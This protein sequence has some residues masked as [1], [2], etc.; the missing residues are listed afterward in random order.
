MTNGTT[1]YGIGSYGTIQS[2]VTGSANN[3]LSNLNTAAASFTLTNYRHFY[4]NQGTIGAG[5][6]ITNQYGVYVESNLT[7]ATNNYGL[8]SIIPSGTNRW[9]LY[10]AGTA[11]NYMAGKLLIGSTTDNGNTL[12]V[13]GALTTSSD[14]FINGVNIG[15]GANSLTHNIRIGAATLLSVTTGD[16]NVAIGPNALQL[17]TTGF[18][19]IAIGRVSLL[20]NTTGNSN[21]AV[22]RSTL[23]ANT[24]GYQNTAIGESSLS[25]NTTGFNNAAFGFYSLINNTTGVQNVA[26]GMSAGRFIADGATANTFVSNS[27]FIG[28]NTKALADSQINQ[29][30]IG[31]NATGL[32]SNTT[33]LGNSSTTLTALYGTVITGGTSANNSAQLQVDSTTKGFLPPRMTAAQRAAIATPATGLMVY[34]TDGTEGVYVF[35]GGSWKSLT[36]V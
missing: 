9:N 5:S 32:G 3:F 22:G 6:A 13:T 34:Q 14:S 23:A 17:N 12:Q 2:D 15:K 30:V 4:I 28:W 18:S 26:L 1:V 33:V 31:H 10:M 21:V 29:V 25:S 24:T 11:A 7:G 8:F 20:S 19:N 27:I 35:S 16:S 36:M